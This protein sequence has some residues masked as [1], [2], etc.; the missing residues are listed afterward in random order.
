MRNE[1]IQKEKDRQ[2]K[3]LKGEWKTKCGSCKKR[4]PMSDFNDVDFGYGVYHKSYW[5]K[6]CDA[7][8]DKDRRKANK[9]WMENQDR[10]LAERKAKGIPR[11]KGWNHVGKVIRYD[12]R[13]G[14]N[15]KMTV[16]CEGFVQTEAWKKKELKKLAYPFGWPK[17]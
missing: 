13:N 12:Y 1:I 5:C 9:K 4:K 14:L 17:N 2:D 10:I 7:Q 16:I 11:L 3:I 15:G 8:M 6:I